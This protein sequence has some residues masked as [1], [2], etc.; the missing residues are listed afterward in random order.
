MDEGQ[1]RL[2]SMYKD[3]SKALNSRHIRF[4][5]GYGTALGAVRHGGFIP[6]DN[7]ID[8]L[9]WEDDLPAVRK[10]LSE[11]LD[12]ERYYY[13][14]PMADSHSHVILKEGDFGE[15][16]KNKTAPFIDIFPLVRYPNR[17]LRGFLSFVSVWAMHVMI[18][19]MDILDSY[20]FYKCARWT[21]PA[22]KKITKAVCNADSDSVTVL[23]TEF[24]K[25][26]CPAEYYGEP[27]LHRFEDTEAPLPR[28]YD[29]LLRISYGDY[30]ELPPEDKRTGAK[31]YPCCAYFDYL[32]ERK[33]NV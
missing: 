18:T 4:Y 6:W 10:A 33:K 5:L 9:V 3:I 20:L 11:E 27:V 2:L 23:T 32:S 19:L 26:I 31:G 15:N 13:H 29:R 17:K 12:P 14:E 22:L 28:E 7:D 1:R 16:L 25:E 8:L 24:R 21:V 30:M